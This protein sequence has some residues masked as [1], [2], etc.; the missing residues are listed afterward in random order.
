MIVPPTPSRLLPRSETQGLTAGAVQP[1]GSTGHNLVV[2][3]DQGDDSYSSF[4]EE[5]I[6]NNLI[7]L[8]A[9]TEEQML[10]QK[11]GNGIPIVV[12]PTASGLIVYVDAYM[13]TGWRPATSA[14]SHC[15]RTFRTKMPSARSR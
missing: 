9:D 13:H 4:T 14:P 15:P 3:N 11:G 10:I 8:D 5:D 2:V 1:P 12:C 7:H 6:L